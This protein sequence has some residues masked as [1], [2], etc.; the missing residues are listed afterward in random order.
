MPR[1]VRDDN[2]PTGADEARDLM[3]RRRPEFAREVPDIMSSHSHVKCRL[4]RRD[5]EGVGVEEPGFPSREP[6]LRSLQHV[7]TQVQTDNLG[8]NLGVRERSQEPSRAASQFHH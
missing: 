4:L 5:R 2:A 8:R 7:W 1:V 6:R 3:H